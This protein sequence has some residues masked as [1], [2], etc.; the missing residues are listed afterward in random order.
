MDEDAFY[1]NP[2]LVRIEIEEVLAERRR[3]VTSDQLEQMVEY[4]I[5]HRAPIF[6][7]IAMVLGACCHCAACLKAGGI[8]PRVE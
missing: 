7:A 5:A 3:L 4:A 6:H 1:A 8:A 2:E